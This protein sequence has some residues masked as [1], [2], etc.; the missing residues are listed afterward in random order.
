MTTEELALICELPSYA[1]FLDASYYLPYSPSIITKYVNNVE[2]E[3]GIK[4]FIRSN[5]SR[6]LQLTNEGE[7]LIGSLKRLNDDWIYIKRQ[8]DDLKNT[9]TSMI[10]I[11][12]QPRFGNYHEQKIISDYMFRNPGAQ[13]IVSK[14]QADELIRHL[15][16]GKLDAAFITFN[17]SMDLDTYFS[18]HGDMITARHII[19]EKDLYA[20]V[21]DKYFKNHSDVL[22][23]ELEDFTFAFPFPDE[24]D[25]QSA[26]ALQSWKEEGEKKGLHLRYTNLHGCDSSAFEIVRQKKIAITAT[27]IP[28]AE[29]EGIRFVRIS[30]W[31]GSTNLYFLKCPANRSLVL[32]Q[33]EA[34]VEDYTKSL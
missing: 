29:H 10:K 23:S 24:N 2:Q 34:C 19:N 8:I 12:S 13:V 5:K 7:S 18:G 27:R 20:G 32:R 25:T 3:L 4:L 21:S 28:A 14:G 1:S 9:N 15:I 16:S 6:N 11:G 33:L 22:L 30:D 31:A 26:R 17:Q